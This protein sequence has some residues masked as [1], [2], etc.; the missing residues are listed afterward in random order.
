MEQKR[1]DCQDFVLGVFIAE[2]FGVVNEKVSKLAFIGQI[3][4]DYQPFGNSDY[5]L[6]VRNVGFRG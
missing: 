2:K 3:G 5:T 6:I 1:C 4:C